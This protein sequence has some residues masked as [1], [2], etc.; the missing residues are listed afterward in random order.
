MNTQ[1]YILW[2]LFSILLLIVTIFLGVKYKKDLYRIVGLNLLVIVFSPQIIEMIQ[3]SRVDTRTLYEIAPIGTITKV[4][5]ILDFN[6]LCL[7]DTVIYYIVRFDSVS[8]NKIERYDS[9]SFSVSITNKNASRNSYGTYMPL[10]TTKEQLRKLKDLDYLTLEKDSSVI[11]ITFLGKKLNDFTWE[12][13]NILKIEK[14]KGKPI[15]I[16]H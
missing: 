10:K 9:T 6:E 1:F 16:S 15:A 2:I 12:C 7:K 13:Q 14:I 8:R 3:N 4:K 5:G 11:Q